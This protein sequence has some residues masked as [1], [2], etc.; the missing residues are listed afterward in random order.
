[1]NPLLVIVAVASI[2]FAAVTHDENPKMLVQVVL[3]S[4]VCLAGYHIII[5][6]A[7]RRESAWVALAGNVGA[8][9]ASNPAELLALF[10]DNPWQS[11]PKEND[12][13][14]VEFALRSAEREPAFYVLD[15][16]FNKL[17]RDDAAQLFTVTFVIVRTNSALAARHLETET[18]PKHFAAFVGGNYLYLYR[19]TSWSFPA[20]QVP[21]KDVPNILAMARSLAATLDAAAA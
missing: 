4:L 8:E 9:L 21:L 20:D 19:K 16:V 18:I 11:W 13:I 7:R 3:M 2:V 12:D 10:T 14:I 1:M 6:Q 15:I 5:R 17:T